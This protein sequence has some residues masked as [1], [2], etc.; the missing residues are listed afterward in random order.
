MFETWVGR[1]LPQ[2]DSTYLKRITMSIPEEEDVSSCHWSHKLAS[3]VVVTVAH[4][5]I[6]VWEFDHNSCIHACQ[7]VFMDTHAKSYILVQAIWRRR[8]RKEKKDS[9]TSIF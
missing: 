4:V 8:R 1:K 2:F 3:D 7:V 9:F 6:G 5:Q